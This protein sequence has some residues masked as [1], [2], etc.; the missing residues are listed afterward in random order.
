[1]MTHAEIKSICST[2]VQRMN[3]ETL[4]E[5]ILW[6]NQTPL[7]DIKN[8]FADNKTALAELERIVSFLCEIPADFNKLEAL[9]HHIENAI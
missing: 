6:F 2:P 3:G 9:R 7:E 4:G 1:M 5:M 8:L